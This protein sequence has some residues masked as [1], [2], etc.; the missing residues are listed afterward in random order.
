MP[1]YRVMIRVYVRGGVE[2]PHPKAL[3]IMAGLQIN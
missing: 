2:E 3:I 1:S